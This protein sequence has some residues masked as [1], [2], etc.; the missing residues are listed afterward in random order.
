[1]G[2]VDQIIRKMNYK[3]FVKYKISIF[4]YLC[5]LWAVDTLLNKITLL[6]YGFVNNLV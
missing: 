1:M 6:K 2:K 4:Y 3:N 5:P